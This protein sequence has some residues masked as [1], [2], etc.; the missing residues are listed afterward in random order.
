MIILLLI[1]RLSP[2]ARTITGVVLA[3]AGLALIGV[4]VTLAAGLLVHGIA[5]TVIGAVLWTS[6]IVTRRRARLAN[7]PLA[8]QPLAQRPNAGVL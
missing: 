1:R 3:A 7:Q 6:A 8:Q 5:L 2:R 4:S